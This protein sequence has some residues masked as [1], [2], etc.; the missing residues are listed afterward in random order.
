MSLGDPPQSSRQLCLLD[1]WSPN[2]NT[3]VTQQTRVCVPFRTQSGLCTSGFIRISIHLVMEKWDS[4]CFTGVEQAPP[5]LH[6]PWNLSCSVMFLSPA[7]SQPEGREVGPWELASCLLV[8]YSRPA[9]ALSWSRLRDVVPHSPSL[10]NPLTSKRQHYKTKQVI[11]FTRF[12]PF[13]SQLLLSANCKINRGFSV[14]IDK[15]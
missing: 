14:G 6:P 7:P 11:L 12:D 9:L 4:T 10:Q 1:K 3:A 5:C 8:P 15:R 2:L 13:I